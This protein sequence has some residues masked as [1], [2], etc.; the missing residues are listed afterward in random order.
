LFSKS[1][2]TDKINHHD[3][4]KVIFAYRIYLCISR[5]FGRRF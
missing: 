3:N 1:Q 4:I 2:N 5:V